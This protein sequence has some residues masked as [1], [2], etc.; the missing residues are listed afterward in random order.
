LKELQ[1][2]VAEHGAVCSAAGARPPRS[3]SG[4]RLAP[5]SHPKAQLPHGRC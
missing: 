5:A 3:R 4:E 1:D 2:S